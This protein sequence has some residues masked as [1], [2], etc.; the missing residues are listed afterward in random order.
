MKL[1]HILFSAFFLM[2]SFIVRGQETD[3]NIF[4]DVKSKDV[5]IPYVTV[6]IETTNIGT[7]TDATGHYMLVNLTPGEYIITARALG[8]KKQSKSI[9]LE[10]GKTIEVNFDLEEDQMAI[11]EVVV[12]GTK[13]FKRSTE[14]AVI[15]N[16][17]SGK[18][19]NQIQANT[20]S[21]SLNFQP[22]L[23]IETDCQTC[24]YTQ[25]RMNGLGGSYSQILI[26]GRPVISALTGLYGLEQF[27]SNMIDRIEVVRGG[28]S[29]LYGSSA[30]GGTVNVITKIPEKNSY[31][32]MI[33]NG[34]IDGRVNDNMIN[35]NV[36]VLTQ[37]RN[38][39][40]SFYASRRT[41]EAF[42]Y[43]GDNYS[44]LPALTNNSFG[45]SM[46]IK[47]SFNQKIE[48]NFSSIHEYRYGGEIVNKPAYLAEQSEERTHK[49]FMGG[50]DY[51]LDFN[52]FHSSFIVYAA[53]QNT[54]R[55]HYTGIIPDD[56]N[57]KLN[58][59]ANPPYGNS[60]NTSFQIGTQLN[61]GI[62]NFLGGNNTLTLGTEF[63]YDDILDRIPA[64]EIEDKPFVDQT[65]RNSGM[66]VQS[67][68]EIFNGF[69]LLSGIRADKHNMVDKLIY[70]PRFSLLY[71]LKYTQL[72]FSWAKGF[73]AP[74]AFDSDLHIAFAGGGISRIILSPDLHEEKSNSF[75]TSINFD[76][77]TEKY[78]FG[79]T[80][81]SFFTNLNDAFILEETGEDYYGLIFEKRNGSESTVKGFTLELRSNYNKKIQLEGGFTLQSSTF[82][83][84]VIYSSEL[85]GTKNFLRSPDDY[86]Y[87]TLTFSPN[88]KFNASL[89]GVYTGKMRLVHLSGAPELPDNDKFVETDT[90][91]V[92]NLKL[93]YQFDFGNFDS[94]FEIFG[95]IKNIFNKYQNDFDTGKYRDSGYIYGPSDPRTFYFG[96]KIKSL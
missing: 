82:S 63:N 62:V 14:S 9:K 91:F 87:Y 41:R 8:Y 38:A 18:T 7:T 10:K 61:H 80:V 57:G 49:I 40:L 21:E 23:R 4:G 70:N 76:Y 71:K 37:K 93:S 79:I 39:G 58:H 33:N 15:V 16:V 59:Y 92:N 74:Q 3:A 75:S 53:G 42:D 51:Q 44:E 95:G 30:I 22:G 31:E 47:P 89:S 29:A 84:E 65:T 12:T 2:L 86:G 17:L 56:S 1:S 50:I 54:V 34:L 67:D 25:L 94:G 66:F 36:N 35:G 69:T 28:G 88:P 27:P 32:L 83:E 20:L 13:T 52:D 73:R 43:N 24:N 78:I 81:E 90:F 55:D 68:W 5:H 46:F 85:S 11:D 6:Y 48:L 45:M 72:R 26:N 60:E 77:P 64:Y 19:I 96:L